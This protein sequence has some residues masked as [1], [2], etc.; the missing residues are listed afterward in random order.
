MYKQPNDFGSIRRHVWTLPFTAMIFAGIFLSTIRGD[1]GHVAICIFLVIASLLPLV[2]ERIWRVRLPTFIQVA[3]VAFLFLSMFS[4]EV[5]GMYSRFYPWDDMMHFISGLFVGFGAMLWLISIYDREKVVVAP[6]VMGLSV[7][8][9]GATIAVLWEVVE[10][11]SDQLFG[12]FTQRQ[13]LFDTMTDLIYGTGSA[14]II[15]LLLSRALAGKYSFGM[16]RI[17]S[18]YRRLNRD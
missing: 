3:Y 7:F 1:M 4:G 12:T 15:A 10:F 14:L 17:I 8:C 18:Y 5:L 11:S 6:W 16:D 2:I 9:I 13:D